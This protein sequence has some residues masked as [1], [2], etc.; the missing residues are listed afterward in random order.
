MATTDPF[1]GER[2]KESPFHPRQAPKNLRDAWSSWNGFKFAD[3]YYDTVYEYFCI[4]NFCGTYDICPMQ[5]YL[6]TGADALAMLNRMV[7]RDLEKLKPER[8]T[9]CCWCTDEGRMID[10]GTIFRLAEDS[11]MLT[12]GSPCIAW[13]RKSMIGFDDVTVRDI[14]EDTAGLS[15]QG[16]TACA[17]L[18]RLGLEGI[19]SL[20]PFGIQR[21]PF[22]G[23]TLMV[24]RTGFTGGLGYELWLPA[25]LALTLWDALY[26]AGEDYG[27]HPYGEAATNMARLE[28]GF[29]MPYMEFSEALKT[30]NFQHDQ[31]PFE[32]GLDWLVDFRKPHFNGRA[33]LL[34]ERERGPRYRLTK[35]AIEGNKV[36]EDAILYNNKR[37]SR[38]VG[39]VTS[40]MWSPAA[41]ANIALA[42]IETRYLDGPIWAEIYY[43]KELRPIRKMA[44]CAVRDKP[45]WSGP[46]ARQTPPPLT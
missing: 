19:D 46:G 26:A 32:L 11:F 6:V 10:D 13:L 28:A 22:H 4:R 7:T 33:A 8:V 18:L 44:R 21:F 20:K 16:P 31:S 15:L 17:V 43:P 25:S 42:M 38:Q 34:A 1:A 30:V 29:I 2:L 36:A 24:S 35:L 45:F 40:A 14:T 37:C 3:Y 5:K 27:I 41:K 12:C 9:Y 39:Y 23:D